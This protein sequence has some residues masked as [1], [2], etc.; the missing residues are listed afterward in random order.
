MMCFVSDLLRYPYNFTI[1]MRPRIT[2]SNY[3]T[4]IHNTPMLYPRIHSIA[5]DIYHQMD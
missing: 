1:V 2:I 5:K 3:Q 4:N